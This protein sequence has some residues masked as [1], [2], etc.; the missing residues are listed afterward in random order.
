M[1]CQSITDD[2]INFFQ[3]L[4]V[5]NKSNEE[6]YQLQDELKLANNKIDYLQTQIINYIKNTDISQNDHTTLFEIQ[7]SLKSI[8]LRIYGKNL[9]INK[10]LLK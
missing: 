1:N 5:C 7:D 10:K 3:N 2:I 4:I 9:A 6:L 8:K